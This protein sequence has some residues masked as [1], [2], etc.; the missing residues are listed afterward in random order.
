MLEL[1][2]ALKY[3]VPRRRSLSTSLI[4]VLS[5]AVISLVVW[6]VLVFLSVV[7][8]IE[9]N[10]IHKLVSLNAPIRIT[11]TEEYYHSYYYQADQFS[12]KSDFSLK[13]IGEKA[14]TSLSNP[15]NEGND[16]A[17]P[18][19]IPL[20]VCKKDGMILDPVKKAYEIL[21][22]KG[23]T[24]QDYEISGALLRLTL[25]RGDA[26]ISTLSQM[27]YLLSLP[28][29]NPRFSSLLLPPTLQD[30]N[31]LLHQMNI[32]RIPST[33]PHFFDSLSSL[34]LRIKP[35]APIPLSSLGNGKWQVNALIANEKVEEIRLSEKPRNGY[36]SAHLACNKAEGKFVLEREDGLPLSLPSD[37]TCFVSDSPL[38][39][40]SL[41]EPKNEPINKQ[42]ISLSGTFQ[43]NPLNIPLS[44]HQIEIANA[45]PCPLPSPT[46]WAVNS[47]KQLLL[48]T[49]SEKET[50]ILLPKAMQESGVLIGDKGFLCYETSSMLSTKEQKLPIYVAGFYDTGVFP[51]GN[52]FLVVPSSITRTIN[53]ASMVFSPDGTPSNGIYVWFDN[54]NQAEQVKAELA[55]AFHAEEIDR[56]WKISTFREYEFSKD[57][58]EQ[59]QSDRTLFMIIALII[60]IVACS[61]VISLLVLLVNDKRKEIAIFQ[62]MGCSKTTIAVIFG[63]SGMITGALSS[64]IG[65]LSAIYT[66][67]HLNFFVEILNKIQGHTA[68]NPAF[69]GNSLPSELS[70]EALLFILI[71]TPLLSLISGLVP[72]IKAARMHPSAILRASE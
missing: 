12:L 5:V 32:G 33:L 25:H 53:G 24:F 70:Y 57:L 18:E 46:L 69:Y 22:N 14:D 40:Y 71:V 29:K 62:S 41:N 16:P 20:P 54:E 35:F 66:L 65:T 42:E 48:P 38:F 37:A 39:E 43:G 21:Q 8:G 67:K 61:N 72:A 51:I 28:D 26:N 52:R 30:L 10:W 11:P 1:F 13:T 64:L 50:S 47:Q 59:F 4:S 2:V 7:T 9:K 49:I 6:L 55:K 60:L 68:F 45:L 56:F 3:L 17:L 19:K 63:L 34:K 31:H 58:I 36:V 15:F 44:F 27:S 23:L